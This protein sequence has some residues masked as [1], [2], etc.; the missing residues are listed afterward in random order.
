MS[1]LVGTSGWSYKEWEKIFYPDSKTPKLSFYSKIFGTVEIDSTFY[2]NPKKGMVFGWA[3]NTPK[4]FQFSAKLPQLITHKKKLDISKGVEVDL[5]N[6]LDL[7]KPLNDTN[8]LGPLL[9]QLP[10]SF[11]FEKMDALEKFF[12]VL[13]EG[14]K[15]A[16]EFRNENWL[17]DT[18]QVQSLLTKYNVSNTIVDEPLL[19]I[20][21][22][23]TSKEFTF[24]RW[25]GRG[26]KLW[27]NYKYSDE[28]VKPW[29]SRV[30]EVA[31]K[32]KTTY[33]YWNN[34]FSAFA[35]ENALTL[36]D[37]LDAATDLQEKTCKKVKD[38]R[39]TH[40]TGINTPTLDG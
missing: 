17:E 6:F 8:K 31:S 37:G 23:V 19:P 39:A 4:N 32:V 7:L 21:L 16:V 2:A 15:F 3:K 30:K 20:D 5:N 25:H 27:Y 14:Y 10:P 9:I 22:S 13:P 26:E 36:L 29:I 12:Q 34:H 40:F 38:Y 18:K 33:G 28:E 1:L 24:V 35:I 11:T